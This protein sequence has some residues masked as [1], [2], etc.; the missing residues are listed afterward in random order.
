MTAEVWVTKNGR[1]I[2]MS[3]MPT[4]HMRNAMAW[5]AREIESNVRRL[6][7]RSGLAA[8]GALEMLVLGRLFERQE[9]LAR[10]W[11]RRVCLI[12]EDCR[13][14]EGLGRACR[15]SEEPSGFDRLQRQE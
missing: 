4:G 8:P 14:D 12:H 15:E 6:Q 9:M 11:D 13:E 5:V 3:E 1:E 2:L 7:A 10:E